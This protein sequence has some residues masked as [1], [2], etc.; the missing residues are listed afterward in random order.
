MKYVLLSAIFSTKNS[1]QVIDT[2]TAQPNPVFI[3]GRPF[4]YIRLQSII[5]F[6]NQLKGQSLHKVR[7]KRS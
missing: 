5:D 1:V 3:K 6:W 4:D 2:Y 7:K